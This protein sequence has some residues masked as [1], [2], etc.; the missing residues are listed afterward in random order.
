M[1]RTKKRRGNMVDEGETKEGLT[2]ELR[3]AT[4]QIEDLA[5]A[6]ANT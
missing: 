3:R 5:L 1:R 4:Q 6:L 2:A